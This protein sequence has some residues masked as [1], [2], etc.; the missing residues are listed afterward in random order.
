MSF[1]Q[2]VQKGRQYACKSDL[3]KYFKKSELLG[4]LTGL[5]KAQ[6]RLNIGIIDGNTP[7]DITSVM[8]IMYSAFYDLI[9]T[10]QLIPGKRYLIKDF[11]TIY[12]SNVYDNNGK[13]ITWGINN[14]VNPSPIQ[15][16]VVSAVTSSRIDPRIIINDNNTKDWHIEYDPTKETLDDGVTTK[17]KITYLKDS[18]NNSAFYD[19]KNIK[20]RR[21]S[22]E[23]SNTNFP[24][25]TS[26]I[27]LFTFSDTEKGVVEDSS[28]YHN[29]KNNT[30]K[31]GCYNNILL[32]DTYNNVFE[33]DCKN[34][35]FI[36]GCHDSTIKWNS[37]NNTF[38][39]NVC[40]V[41]GSIYNKF[42]KIGNTDFSTTINKTINKVNDATLLAFL[43]PIT[44]AQQIIII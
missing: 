28:Y 43:D 34:N 41:E 13:R 30:L 23:L 7:G 32:G 31:E 44:Y 14:S 21:T 15:Q 22:L 36:R 20:F 19:F 42:I 16:I 40:F 26:F 10:N 24:I 2:E 35:M 39:E 1:T 17:G 37:V 29:T 33:E 8:E 25:S 11:Q 5:E 6:L 18:N 12:S 3:N 38:N 27:D 4:G 9:L